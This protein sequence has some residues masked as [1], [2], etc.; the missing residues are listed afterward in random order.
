M[1]NFLQKVNLALNKKILAIL[2][3]ISVLSIIRMIIFQTI[4][5]ILA[6]QF[7][8]KIQCNK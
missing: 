1:F 8:V 4:N 3:H 6:K 2:R 5:H 7:W